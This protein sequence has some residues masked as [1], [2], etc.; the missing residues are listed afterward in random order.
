MGSRVEMDAEELWSGLWQI[1]KIDSAQH[2]SK[3]PSIMASSTIEARRLEKTFPGSLAAR[4]SICHVASARK[5]QVNQKWKVELS[6]ER[7]WPLGSSE[8]IGRCVGVFQF[9]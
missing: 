7:R 1:L 6:P 2:P 5:M 4:I 8:Y 3:P 9:F